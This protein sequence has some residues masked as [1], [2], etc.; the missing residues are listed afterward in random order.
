VS[1]EELKDKLG[2]L[3]HMR[4]ETVQQRHNELVEGK[5]TLEAVGIQVQRRKSANLL[6]AGAAGDGSVVIK[7]MRDLSNN[8]NNKG[9]MQEG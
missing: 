2:Q 5:N 9:G 1:E 8:K 6:A 3:K 7:I 4:I